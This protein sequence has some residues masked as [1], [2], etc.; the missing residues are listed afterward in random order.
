MNLYKSGN[1]KNHFRKFYNLTSSECKRIKFSLLESS[2]WAES[3]D[4][5][6]TFLEWIN[7]GD[8]I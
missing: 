7:N 5:G 6:F 2:N 3:N 1:R 4:N 8:D